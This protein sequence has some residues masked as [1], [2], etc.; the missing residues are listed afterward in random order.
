MPSGAY[1]CGRRPAPHNP[2]VAGSILPPP[3]KRP[4]QRIYLTWSCRVRATTLQ[5]VATE[6]W[7]RSRRCRHERL[8]DVDRDTPSVTAGAHDAGDRRRAPEVFEHGTR[9]SRA[10]A[11]TVSMEAA[12]R[13]DAENTEGCGCS[14]AK[15]LSDE[16]PPAVARP[17]RLPDCQR[18]P[19]LGKPGLESWRR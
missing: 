3:Q 19:H 12:E 15:D 7:R 11:C 8:R 16:V 17:R 9:R 5:P 10:L 13:Q 4:G 6:R 14:T 18:R 2:K 1:T